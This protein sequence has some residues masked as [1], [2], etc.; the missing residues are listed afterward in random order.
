M[1]MYTQTIQL[2]CTS[3]SQYYVSGLGLCVCSIKHNASYEMCYTL[4]WLERFASQETTIIVVISALC[5]PI[6]CKSSLHFLTLL[7]ML[8]MFL[9]LLVDYNF[10]VFEYIYYCYNIYYSFIS[11]QVHTKLSYSDLF[12][13]SRG[14]RTPRGNPESHRVFTVRTPRESHRELCTKR[15]QTAPAGDQN[16]YCDFGKKNH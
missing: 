2:W 6:L 5:V 13:L 14:V 15:I 1:H 11:T 8:L 3:F 9:L 4:S 10:Y 16:Q 7:Q 12:G